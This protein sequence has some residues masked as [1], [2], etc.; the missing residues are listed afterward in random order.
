MT[1]LFEALS[2]PFAQTTV[3]AAGGID[4]DV[5]ATVL[6]QTILFF[7]FVT[8]MKPLIFDPL[9]RV[10]EERERRTAGAV[11]RARG[12]DEEAIAL[13]HKADEQLDAAR[14]EASAERDANRAALAKQRSEKTESPQARPSLLA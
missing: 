12:M 5:N 8:F 7:A 13:K 3:F 4:I 10:F 2:S 1:H 14:R 6:V 11:D 9:L